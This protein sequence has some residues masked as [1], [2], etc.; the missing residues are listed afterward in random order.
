MAAHYKVRTCIP[1]HEKD[2]RAVTAALFPDGAILSGS[3]DVTAKLWV[4]N[5]YEK[6]IA[7]S[8]SLYQ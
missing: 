8:H 1:A 4:P 6:L 7:L 5:E 2:V 3:R